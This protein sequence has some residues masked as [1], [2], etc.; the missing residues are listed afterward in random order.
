M[1]TEF[2]RGKSLKFKARLSFALN[3]DD[4]NVKS[5]KIKEGQELLYDGE[6][7]VVDNGDGLIKGRCMGLKSAI[8]VMDWLTPIKNGKSSKVSEVPQIVS[9]NLFGDDDYDPRLGGNLDTYMKRN[10]MGVKREVIKEEDLIVKKI[11]PIN[12]K[13]EAPRKGKLEIAGDQVE[14]PKDRLVVS[15]STVRTR[16]GKRDVDVIQADEMGAD[17]TLPLKGQKKAL[18][19]TQKK[20][21]FIV[22]DTTPRPM[23]NDM[24]QD[25]IRRITK[26][27]NADE[28]QDA[29]VV[30]RIDRSKMEVKEVEGITLKKTISPKDVKFNKTTTPSGMT[31]KTTVGSGNN[32]S[33][34]DQGGVVV[35]VSK[36]AKN[37]AEKTGKALIEDIL[38]EAPEPTEEE[39]A[40]AAAKL[41]ERT[42]KAKERADNR[43]KTSSETQKLMEKDKKPVESEKID[44][45]K[46]PEL[47]KEIKVKKKKDKKVKNATK[48]SASDATTD[49]LLTLPDNWNKMHWVKKEQFIKKQDDHYFI[50]FILS[51]EITKAVRN[52]CLERLK[53]LGQ[54]ESG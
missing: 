49:F 15:S 38:D 54:E 39:K 32:Y 31:V 24:T 5:I 23:H 4:R 29:K 17:S 35:G 9:S 41:V 6:V 2:T 18:T 44:L 11:S 8:N 52:A 37:K 30:K 42:K 1:F 3:W 34:G 46:P 40:Q 12:K 21:G 53:E 36:T 20:K 16:I 28:S 22:N 14:V 45:D 50:K 48:M 19:Q 27:I 10:N 47:V 13:S 51:M 26:V 7:A 43:K 33:V 25:E